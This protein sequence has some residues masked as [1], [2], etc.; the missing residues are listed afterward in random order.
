MWV[1]DKERRHY[2]IINSAATF[3]KQP[4]VTFALTITLFLHAT[5]L[6]RHTHRASDINAFF[7]YNGNIGFKDYAGTARAFLATAH[8]PFTIVRY[9]AKT[10]LALMPPLP[11]RG[12]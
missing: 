12:V 11:S 3:L 4:R 1:Y 7:F 5:V 2:S 6:Y 9:Q 8:T 10:R